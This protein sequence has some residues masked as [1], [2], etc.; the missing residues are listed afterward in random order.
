[1]QPDS[2]A[3]AA[4]EFVDLFLMEM[5]NWRWSWRLLVFGGA[6]APLALMAGLG[7]FARDSGEAALRYVL[8]GNVV[9]TILLGNMDTLQ[10]RFVFMRLTGALD[11]YGT[12]PI[13]RTSLIG[14]I[15]A[16]FLLLSLPAIAVTVIFGSWML[17]V[18]LDASPLLLIVLPLAAIPVA[19]IG[20][21]IGLVSPTPETGNLLRF[22]TAVTLIAIGPVLF[23]PERLPEIMQW[24]GRL[25]PATYAASALRQTLLGPVS[26]RLVLDLSVLLGFG[27]IGLWFVVRRLDWRRD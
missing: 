8:T 23:P 2:R 24:L 15:V 7:V 4:A 21:L 13:R 16:S 19:A 14:A 6:V 18:P 27:A 1:M 17:G 20:A 11:Y 26:S 10:S 9:L 3:G 25:S 22:V 5:T 12:L